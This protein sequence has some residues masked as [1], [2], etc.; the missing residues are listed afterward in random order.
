MFG[1]NERPVVFCCCVYNSA[2]VHDA[3]PTHGLDEQGS[4]AA[5]MVAIEA[6][7]QARA[8][9]RHIRPAGCVGMSVCVCE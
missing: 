4:C 3:P 1:E 5:T 8:S 2:D 9:T 6:D 7:T